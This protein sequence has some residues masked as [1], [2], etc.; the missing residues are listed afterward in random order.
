MS[1]LTNDP[2]RDDIAKRL[3]RVAG[4]ANS[5]KSPSCGQEAPALLGLCWRMRLRGDSHPPAGRPRGSPLLWTGLESRFPRGIVGATLVVARLD[6]SMLWS[7]CLPTVIRQQRLAC[8]DQKVI[9][10]LMGNN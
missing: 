3:A 4:H 2:S 7:F 10:Y 5:L 8:P 9:K 6:R 1:H